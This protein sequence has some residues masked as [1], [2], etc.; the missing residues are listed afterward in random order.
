MKLF[1]FCFPA[2]RVKSA[3]GKVLEFSPRSRGII[4]IPGMD[5]VHHDFDPHLVQ[6]FLKE[7]HTFK[8]QH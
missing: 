7:K 6:L 5:S 1:S 2:M 8:A 4:S 3:N